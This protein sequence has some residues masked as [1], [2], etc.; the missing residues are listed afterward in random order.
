M[1]DALGTFT[2]PES[3]KSHLTIP[4]SRIYCRLIWGYTAK[5][6]G[7]LR[8]NSFRKNERV[9]DILMIVLSSVDGVW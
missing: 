6:A 1:L 4:S 2:L 9:V 3:N 7:E 5:I 8:E